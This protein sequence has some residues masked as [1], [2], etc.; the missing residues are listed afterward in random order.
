MKLIKKSDDK[1]GY[2]V[3]SS[4]ADIAESEPKFFKENFNITFEFAK[5]VVY[6]KEIE[7]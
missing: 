7:D 2:D 5:W 3:L 1:Y 4:F 6:E